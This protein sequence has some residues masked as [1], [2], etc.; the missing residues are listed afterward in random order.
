[1]KKPGGKITSLVHRSMTVDFDVS[2]MKQQLLFSMNQ[3]KT[4]KITG[5]NFTVYTEL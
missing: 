5:K 1:M 2:N 4:A 3:R